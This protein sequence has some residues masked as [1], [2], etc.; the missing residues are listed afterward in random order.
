M[1][2]GRLTQRITLQTRTETQNTFGET[3]WTW[4]DLDTVWA[5]VEPLTG[6][7]RIA[8]AQVQSQSDIRIR[9]RHRDD[10]TTKHRVK[11]TVHGTARYYEIEVVIPVLHKRREV[12]LMC[13]E[14]EADGWR[15]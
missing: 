15:D 7:E 1:R 14:R 2:A 5:A 11:H 4:T 10:L 9:I 8:A 12:H 3:T 6:T 13:K